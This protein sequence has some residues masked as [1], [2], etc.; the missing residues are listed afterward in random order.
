MRDHECF[1][2][3][4]RSRVEIGTPFCP[5]GVVDAHDSAKVVDQVR[6]LAGTLNDADVTRRGG[7]LQS[8]IKWVRLPPASLWIE[9]IDVIR[10]AAV[11]SLERVLSRL[12]RT[13][14]LTGGHQ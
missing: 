11:G 5:W 4:R 13:W 14:V 7:G 6:L 10:P 1:I 8:R 9:N 2:I 12:F 3:E